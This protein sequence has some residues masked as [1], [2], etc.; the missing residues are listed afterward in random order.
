[1]QDQIIIAHEFIRGEIDPRLHGNDNFEIC[2]TYDTGTNREFI[3]IILLAGF[4]KS[5][6][7]KKQLIL[8]F[9][10][11]HIYFYSVCCFIFY[12]IIIK[13]IIFF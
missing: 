9:R 7:S 11:L 5:I 10:Y 2:W 6:I 12:K 1:M 3:F 13:I 8:T 4:E